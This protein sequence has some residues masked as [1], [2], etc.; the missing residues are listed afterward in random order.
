[1]HLCILG[2]SAKGVL[3]VPLGR[4][5]L[6]SFAVTRAA[7]RLICFNRDTSGSRHLCSIGL[8]GGDSIYLG[9]LSTNVL[10]SVAL[11]RIRS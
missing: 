11:N 9:S 3:P 4:S 7:P 5:V 1:M 6:S 2:P 8:G 10:G